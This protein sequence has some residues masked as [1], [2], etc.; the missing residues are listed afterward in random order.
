ME[1]K[2]KEVKKEIISDNVTNF[3]YEVYFENQMVYYIDT[4]E[5]NNN[6]WK[7][8]YFT[9]NKNKLEYPELFLTDIYVNTRIYDD[10][11]IEIQTTSYGEM[12]SE[13]ISKVIKGYQIA[14]AVVDAIEEKFFI[15]SEEDFLNEI[16]YSKEQWNFLLSLLGETGAT[17]YESIC[18]IVEKLTDRQ[19]NELIKELVYYLED[20]AEPENIDS[21]IKRLIVHWNWCYEEFEDR[22]D[23][24][25]SKLGLKGN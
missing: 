3:D 7:Y 25:E 15:S 17:G 6:K 20:N 11:P 21:F 14:Q 2:I 12:K 22:V 24:I 8:T 4:Q 10:A 18:D 23:K 9:I 5:D 16:N 19:K 13:D 1:V